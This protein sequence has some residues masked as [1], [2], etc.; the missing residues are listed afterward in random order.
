MRISFHPAKRILLTSLN[1]CVLLGLGIYEHQ[2]LHH[3]MHLIVE[4]KENLFDV[5]GRR[6]ELLAPSELLEYTDNHLSFYSNNKNALAYVYGYELTSRER[7]AIYP[8]ED[9]ATAT[10][11]IYRYILSYPDV[12]GL[13]LLTNKHIL[14]GLSSERGS[15]PEKLIDSSHDLFEAKPWQHFFDCEKFKTYKKLCSTDKS[16]VSDISID[17][18][19]HKKIFVLYFPF[20]LF[21][22]NINDYQY[23]LVGIDIDISSAFRDTLNPFEKNNPTQSLVS[24]HSNECPQYH[25]CF[26]QEIMR[27]NANSP[28]YLIWNYRIDDFIYRQLNSSVFRLVVIAYLI[29]ILLWKQ[30]S[31]SILKQFYKDKL[32][33]LPRRDLLN[34]KMLQ[35]YNYLLLIDID[36]FKFINDNLGHEMG[37]I[38]LARFAD[39]ITQQLRRGDQALRWGGEE[40]LILLKAP[41]S[42]EK[43]EPM[44]GRLLE[45]LVIDDIEKH[46][47]FSGGLVHITQSLTI[48]KAV[49]NADKLLYEVKKNGKNNIAIKKSGST[50]FFRKSNDEQSDL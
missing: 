33:N 21:N 42:I 38:V 15:L 30:L 25:I 49:N 29:I 28:L 20:V 46:I 37:D 10:L 1:I 36:N 44:I 23:G 7:F 2:S 41:G 9:G 16:F 13:Y 5:F 50:F 8:I 12:V 45:P 24:F 32:T 48:E 18:L 47:T 27:T 34:E 39:K 4:R 43:I 31:P 40:F 3:D 26:Q 19:T 22:Y 14:I 35:E 11:P 6:A 17:I